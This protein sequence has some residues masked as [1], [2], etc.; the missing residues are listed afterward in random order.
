MFKIDKNHREDIRDADYKIY[1]M[2]KKNTSRACFML[3][4]SIEM[5]I[6]SSIVFGSESPI[7]QDI[8]KIWNEYLCIIKQERK[9]FNYLSKRKRDID[10]SSFSVD[11]F[12]DDLDELSEQTD[13]YYT[14]VL[15]DIEVAC[16]MH[17][18]YRAKRMPKVFETLVEDDSFIDDMIQGTLNK[19]DIIKFLKLPRK[20]IKFMKK[21]SFRFYELSEEE[22]QDFS[23]Y[24]V[25]YKE[26]ENGSLS[27]IKLIVPAIMDLKTA[28]INISEYHKAYELYQRLG[29]QLQD[30]EINKIIDSSKRLE[31][32]FQKEFQKR[33]ITT[34]YQ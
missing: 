29:N 14:Q 6:K 1:T 4:F 7:S 23:L 21:D 17:E 2:K 19:K 13:E 26:D 25:N 11:G 24:G 5:C 3:L 28:L 9:I 10:Y 8:F 12:L 20:F 18:E 33:K 27:D 22:D 34:K 32:E 15:E 31:E 30:D 16:Q